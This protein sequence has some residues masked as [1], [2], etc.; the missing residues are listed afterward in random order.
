MRTALIVFRKELL[1]TLRDRRTI[2][3]M[4][5]I[6]LLLFP[7]MIGLSS[8][9]ITTHETEA[10]ARML[11]VGVLYRDNAA[12]FSDLLAGEADV[13]VQ[14]VGD[15]SQATELVLADSLDAL[16]AFS[17]EFDSTVAAMGQGG[18]AVY[19]KQTEDRA[20]EAARITGLL[21]AYGEVLRTER[22]RQL[23]LSTAVYDV[24]SSESVNLATPKERL[25]DIV[26]G[27]LPYMFVIFCFMGSMYPAIDLAAGEKERGTLETLLTSPVNRMPILVGKFGVV[28]LTGITSAAVSLLGLYAGIRYASAVPQEFVDMVMSILE[29]SSILLLISLLFPLTVFFAALLLSVSFLARS[30]KEAQS[31]IGP[32]YPVIIIPAFIGLMPGMEL[33][34][35]TALVPILNV[36]LATKAIIAGQAAAGPMAL[37]YASLAVYAAAGL[38]LCSRIFARESAIFR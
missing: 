17:Q 13:S 34:A 25:A 2:I 8:E 35:S 19:M 3:T 21:D 16:I 1:D 26:G 27:I 24:I 4:I 38:F 9:F 14:A 6:P 36:S 5:L 28:V 15:L 37:V 33:S 11:Q 18:V 32:L 31:M 20:I 7:L 23:G 12:G 29:P 22:F 10:Q 30:F